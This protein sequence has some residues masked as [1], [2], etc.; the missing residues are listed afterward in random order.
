LRLEEKIGSNYKWIKQN[1]TK[2]M[3]TKQGLMYP[4][5]AFYLL[6]G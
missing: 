6:C 2:Q 1:K 3:K 4:R 5:L